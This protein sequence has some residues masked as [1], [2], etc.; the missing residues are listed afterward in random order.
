[1]LHL[2]QLGLNRNA[3]T[4]CCY[5]FLVCAPS[6]EG[7]RTLAAAQAGKEGYTS[8]LDRAQSWCVDVGDPHSEERPGV[9][10]RARLSD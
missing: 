4:D 10:L 7:A 5:G 9:M 3:T 8:W 6:E 2:Y 1:M